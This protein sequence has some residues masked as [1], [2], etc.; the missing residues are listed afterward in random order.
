MVHGTGGA[1]RI[2]VQDLATGNLQVL[3]DTQLDESPTFSPNGSMIMYATEANN[4]GVLEV[5]SVDGRMHQTLSLRQ[6]DVREPAWSP[7]KH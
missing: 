5:V 1:F 6:G 7:F 4:H 2:A 3:T